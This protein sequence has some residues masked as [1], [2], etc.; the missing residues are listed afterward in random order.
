MS[1][2]V[3]DV[4]T[5]APTPASGSMVSFGA[6]MAKDLT[7]TFYGKTKP[8][9]DRFD[10]ERL[11]ISNVT[12]GEHLTFDDPTIVMHDFD[13]WI[14]KNSKG[15]PIFISDNNG[16]DFAW[17]SYYFDKYI[18]SNPF[19]WS[20]RRLGDLYCGMTM[21]TFARWKHL[22][23]TPHDH[24]PVNDAIANATVIRIMKEMGLKIK[25]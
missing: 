11:A 21:D 7:E 3:V 6:V 8:I 13:K 19:G 10:P 12:R 4:E 24:N 5:D 17:I 25:L 20:S 1:Y 16:F 15:R 14:K 23:T 22:R 2:I 18:G 9:S